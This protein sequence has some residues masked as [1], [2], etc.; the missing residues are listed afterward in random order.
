MMTIS[1]ESSLFTVV[2]LMTTKPDDQEKLL[3][4]FK[5]S[6]QGMRKHPGFV[7]AGLHKGVDGT[8]ILNYLQW[9]SQADF[10]AFVS[11]SGRA[12]R[13]REFRELLTEQGQTQPDRRPYEVVLV[14]EPSE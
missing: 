6:V 5:L 7:A 11:R 2:T 4:A 8:S 1:A 12:E 10:E 14:A 3:N 13:E 9:R